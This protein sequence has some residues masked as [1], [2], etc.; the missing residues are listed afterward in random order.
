MHTIWY[1]RCPV[2]TASG[3]AFQR[4]AF[5]EAFAGS[6]YVV[7][8]IR[9]LGREKADSHFDHSLASSFREGGAIPPMWARQG[10]ADTCLVGLTFVADALRFY[11]RA[12]DPAT[13]FADLAGRR[14]GVAHRP[15]L[16]IDFMR[17]NG[18]KAYAAALEVHGM[19]AGDIRYTP[20]EIHDDMHASI[21][22]NYR[23]ADPGGNAH[24]K[25]LY[26]TEIDALLEGRIDCFFAK[27]AECGL[28]ER[29][30]AGRIRPVYDLLQAPQAR[31]KVNANPRIITVSGN[32]VRHHPQAVVDYLRVLVRTARWASEN[33]AAA[34]DTMAAEL[35][36][37]PEDITACY[38]RDFQGK[39]WPN[40]SAATFE[41]LEDQHRFMVENG[42]LS[43]PLDIPAWTRA[44][45]LR[46][47][48]ECEAV[49]WAA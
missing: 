36:V 49:P 38:E 14:L 2:A 21:N 33:P 31:F 9:E 48:C 3:L 6:D 15:Y 34:R 19:T 10:G 17:V 18:H 5:D 4:K 46:Q 22:A 24:R 44:E 45:F 7:R 12:D 29:Q 47:A 23:Q 13:G 28:I 27:N 35:G 40:L 16:M 30:F 20:V 11:V 26:Q 42:Y 43:E 41:L 25:S 1:T 8:N 37:T 32:L 39:L